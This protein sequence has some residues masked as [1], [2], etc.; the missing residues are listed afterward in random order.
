MKNVNETQNENSKDCCG[1]EEGCGQCMKGGFPLKKEFL[2]FLTL[3]LV[4]TATVLSVLFIDAKRD[5]LAVQSE[6]SSKVTEKV[7]AKTYEMPVIKSIKEV[8]K[9][10]SP[11]L[12]GKLSVEEAIQTRRSKRVFSDEPVTASQLGQILWS[13]QGITDEAGHRTAPS[14]RSVYPYSLYVVVRNVTGIDSGLYLYNPVDHSLGSLGLA[15]AGEILASSGVQDNSQKAPV[16]I[17]MTAAMAKAAVSFPDNPEEVAF[18]EGG[19]IGQ[20]IY[21]QAESLKMAT[22]VTAGFDAAKVGEMLG[23]D[24]N[25]VIVY[26]VPFGHIGEEA[27]VEN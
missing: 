19:H 1:S 5:L 15:N 10:P 17:A 23:L 25:E 18:L 7:S 16:V 8:V 21:L 22:V 20:N 26:L 13:A 11:K 2:S 12:S 3:F 14:A 27:L 4:G 6:S 24:K 9:L